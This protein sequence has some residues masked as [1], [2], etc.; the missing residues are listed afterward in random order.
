MHA[1][2]A[3]HS[4]R[5]INT[6]GPTEATVVATAC[7]LNTETGC[8]PSVQS[9]VPIGQPLGNSQVYIL[10]E[11]LNPVPIG[12]PGE[13]YIGGVGV[14]RGYL[15]QPAR[16]EKKFIPHPFID[17]P[18]ARLYKTGDRACR[19]ANGNIEFLG[20]TDHQVKIRG[21]RVEP[22]EVESILGDHAAVRESV[23][24]LREDAPD[25]KRL[26]AYIVPTSAAPSSSELRAFLRQR[27][28]NYMV[29]SVFV[30]L[31]ALPL[32]TTGKVDR[33]ALP[34]PDPAGFRAEN[35]YAAPRASVEEVLAG[36]FEEVLGV[37][38]VGIHDDFFEL[39]GH[40]LLAT[41]VVSSVRE[42]FQVELPL[43]SFF[44]EPTI[45]GLVEKIEVAQK[46][47]L[48][49]PTA[50]LNTPSSDDLDEE[51]L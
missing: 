19:R 39:G 6:Y 30:M 45:A 4:A 49:L 32:T 29:P 13:L 28:P 22:G 18:R 46:A 47:N 16:T 7:E 5:L 21:F 44:E 37:A 12:V 8:D 25:Q 35:A 41:Q 20:R 33:R 42:V 40:S 34:A 26:A 36:I 14:A 3:S 48:A 24:L 17:E 38:R 23:V 2:H 9:E 15:N 1:A 31:E 50:M 10:D 43:R 11:Y 51:R 27:L